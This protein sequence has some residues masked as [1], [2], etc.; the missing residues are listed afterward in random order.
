M[1]IESKEFYRNIIR[2]RRMNLEPAI[3]ERCAEE[4]L[5][6]L[7]NTGDKEINDILKGAKT[8][9]LYRA[10][11]GE[12]NVDRIAKWCLKKG[13]TTCFPKTLGEKIEFFKASD[14]DKD[15]VSGK[16]G[17]LEPKSTETVNIEDIDVVIV[18]AFA[19][20]DE[21]VRLGAGGGYYDRFYADCLSTGK[22][23][24]FVGICYDFQINSG[25]PVEDYDLCV[26]VLLTVDTSEDF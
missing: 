17:I 10:I 22:V 6:A 4:A 19:Y 11:R 14:L 5:Q 25:I 1:S 26:D 3:L 7:L 8:V 18:P 13:K 21:G 20:N 2:D 12:L 24:L 23:P 9:A 15:F 16:Y